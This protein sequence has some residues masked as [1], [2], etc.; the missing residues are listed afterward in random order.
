M[1]R[2]MDTNLPFPA[3]PSPCSSHQPSCRPVPVADHTYFAGHPT[4]G[5]HGGDAGR[6]TEKSKPRSPKHPPEEALSAI[7]ERAAMASYRGYL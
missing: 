1:S 2:V 4:Y 3:T 6:K 7:K 5:K